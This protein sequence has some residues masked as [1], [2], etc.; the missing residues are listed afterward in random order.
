MKRKII[1]ILILLILI[2]L[3][4]PIGIRTYYKLSLNNKLNAIKLDNCVIT[5]NENFEI[6]GKAYCQ[7]D[8]T[9]FREYK[10]NKTIRNVLH[11]YNTNK[12]YEY[13]IDN[14]S[15]LDEFDSESENFNMNDLSNVEE[16]NIEQTI[17]N[18]N[19]E[20]LDSYGNNVILNCL[21]DNKNK[22]KSIK[23]FDNCY[24][25]IF[26]TNDLDI[27]IIVDS[28]TGLTNQII[29]S[30][31]KNNG[32]NIWDISYN[33]DVNISELNIFPDF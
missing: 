20:I 6:V 31:P 22:L 1:F 10:G 8:K 5:W 32:L 13:T 16:N 4:Y 9:L 33:F 30:T 11:D 17:E 23:K 21:N 26:E 19:R 7:N 25:F 15:Y 24:R 2:F 28:K 14:S 18:K 12:S 3:F 27:T 29:T